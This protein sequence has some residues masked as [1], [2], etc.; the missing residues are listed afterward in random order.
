VSAPLGF[1]AN[2]CLGIGQAL[3]SPVSLENRYKTPFKLNGTIEQVEAQYMT[4]TN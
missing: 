2:D 4:K 1:T 3:G